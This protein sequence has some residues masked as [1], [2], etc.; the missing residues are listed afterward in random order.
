MS[1]APGRLMNNITVTQV[2]APDG[3]GP[4]DDRG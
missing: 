1:L 2:P 3:F 4:P